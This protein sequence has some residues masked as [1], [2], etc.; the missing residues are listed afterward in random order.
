MTPE[1]ETRLFE[2]KNGP[3]DG[4]RFV[5]EQCRHHGW[6]DL[7]PVDDDNNDVGGRY[8]YDEDADQYTWIGP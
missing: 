6:P 4:R 3:E 1:T 2:L 7:I 8:R 5:V